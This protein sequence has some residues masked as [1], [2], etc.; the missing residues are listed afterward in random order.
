MEEANINKLLK[1]ETLIKEVYNDFDN[2]VHSSD[3]HHKMEK[4][5]GDINSIICNHGR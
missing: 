3:F 1:A 2:I 4:I 5:I